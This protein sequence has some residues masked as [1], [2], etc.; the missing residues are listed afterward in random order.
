[1]KDIRIIMCA[2]MLLLLGLSSAAQ[3]FSV[4]TNLVD[5]ALLDVNLGVEAAVAPKWTVE[6][7]VSFN[8]WTLSHKRRWKHWAVQPGV[9]YWLCDRFAGHFFGA[10]L[11][12]GQ[13][14]IGGI[15][16]KINIFGTDLRKLKDSRYQGWFVG[17]G[18]SYGYTWILGRHWNAEAEIGLGYAYTRYDRYGCSGCGKKE[19]TGRTHHYVGPTKA[20]IN[21]VYVF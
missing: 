18:V 19:A 11:H 21:L 7:P 16:G 1:M 5:D 12:G 13:Y 15:D 6:M 8:A 14:N 9:R 4:K 3:D 2:L 10:H 20:A 17:A